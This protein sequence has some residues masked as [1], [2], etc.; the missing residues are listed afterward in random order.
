[1]RIIIDAD[2]F[3]TFIRESWR[4][5]LVVLV[6]SVVLFTS[7]ANNAAT[8]RHLREVATETHNALCAFKDDLATRHKNG[9]EFLKNHP[10]GIEG[11]PRETIK[12]SLEA[13]R[14]TLR[15]LSDLTC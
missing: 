14:D 9:Q 11:I 4:G 6:T 13:Q 8:E 7:T 10:H 2:T 5:L 3:K 1:M 12:R 15:A